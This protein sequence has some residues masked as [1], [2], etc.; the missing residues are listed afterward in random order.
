MQEQQPRW[1]EIVNKQKDPTYLT[2]DYKI[3]RS[4]AEKERIALKNYYSGLCRD[5][6]TD[7]QKANEERL[8]EHSTQVTLSLCIELEE[9]EKIHKEFKG[10]LEI[11][12]DTKDQL[13]VFSRDEAAAES[14]YIERM[15]A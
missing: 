10:A 5:E 8:S 13:E 1:M 3:E 6:R 14:L 9:I 2:V 11:V 4:E 12:T 7:E 15:R